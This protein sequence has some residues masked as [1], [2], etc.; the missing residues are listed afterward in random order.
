MSEFD[1]PI[2]YNQRGPK[3]R[4]AQYTL[5]GN[6]FFKHDFLAGAP[7]GIWG[8]QSMAASDLARWLLG[9]P[10]AGFKQGVFGQNLFDYLRTDS[11]RV[12]LPASYVT[13]RI[14]R[15]AVA[16]SHQ[17]PG[18]PG[19]V[20]FPRYWYP[21]T[22]FKWGLQPWIVPQVEA[23]CKHFGLVVTAGHGGHPPHAIFSD[24]AWGG[25]SD[26]AGPLQNMINCTFWADGLS[27]GAYR[28][29][30]V[31]RWVGGPA[32]DANGIEKGHY[33]HV[34]LSWYR[35]GPATTVFGKAGFPS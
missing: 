19:H 24:H 16:K 3:V 17:I 29:G 5:N 35:Y 2:H 9:W 28:R 21:P 14:K 1:P 31:F 6:N 30:K 13:R 7:D 12:K 8:K 33:N 10:A 25:A 26:L 18:L 34:H 23:I 20:W 4:D 27:S 32:H 11:E 22:N 15:L